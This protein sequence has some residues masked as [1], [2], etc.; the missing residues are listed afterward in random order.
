M[1]N[2][3]ISL[4]KLT[5]LSVSLLSCLP[6]ILIFLWFLIKNINR[7]NQPFLLTDALFLGLIISLNIILA[8]KLSSFLEKM[9]QPFIVAAKNLNQSKDKISLSKL[10]TNEFFQLGDAFNTLSDQVEKQNRQLKK[11]QEYDKT[12]LLQRVADN[13]PG[14]IFQSKLTPSGSILTYF[15][16][17][18]LEHIYA[19]ADKSQEERVHELIDS[20][21]QTAF[22]ELLKVMRISAQTMQPYQFDIETINSRGETYWLSISGHPS[23]KNNDVHWDGVAL[24]ITERKNVETKMWQQA[25]I[26]AITQLNNRLSFNQHLA[27]LCKQES[28]RPFSLLFFDLDNFKDIN[29]KYGHHIGD[30]VLI[31]FAEQVNHAFAA[32]ESSFLARVGGDEFC[33]I[34]ANKTDLIK[35]TN[36]LL[37]KLSLPIDVEGVKLY[38]QVSVGMANWPENGHSAEAILHK[39]DL[40]M[41]SSKEAGGHQLRQ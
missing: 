31:T 9:I 26:D 14:M 13:L 33:V 12:L 11:Q 24:D 10:K 39:A 6:T 16:S 20:F 32:L 28:L 40:A 3:R 19:N 2:T 1:A 36:D 17:Y 30:Q 34:A 7:P 41:Y 25:H 38:I 4:K 35:K 22:P 37:A 8:I 21:N 29:D 15:L 18:G 23:I 5:Q 27:I